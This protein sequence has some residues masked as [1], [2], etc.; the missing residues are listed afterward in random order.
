MPTAFSRLF[1]VG[2]C[3]KHWPQFFFRYDK[4]LNLHEIW[5]LMLE[6][7]IQ[8]CQN[9]PP[10]SIVHYAHIQY[11]RISIIELVKDLRAM[12]VLAIFQNDPWQFMDVRALT[13]IF[14]VRSCKTR[15][16]FAKFFLPT[17]KNPKC[18]LINIFSPTFLPNWMTSACKMSPGMPKEAGSLNGPLRAYLIG[19][20][21]HNR[22]RPRS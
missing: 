22:T 14:R 6:K 7:L 15:K 3:E 5:W 19:K 13:V 2:K 1:A 9:W 16:Q 10:H 17:M 18:I 20:N 21:F 8:E 4:T 11:D 12:N